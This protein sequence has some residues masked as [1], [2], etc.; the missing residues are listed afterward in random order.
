MGAPTV[1]ATAG[2][3]TSRS[4]AD[5]EVALVMCVQALADAPAARRAAVLLSRAGEHGLGPIALGLV[6]A[7]L[8]PGQRRSWLRAVVAVA[9]AHALAS[10]LKRLVRRPR[11]SDPRVDVRLAAPSPWSFPS[12][13]AASTTA[14]ALAYSRLLGR[15]LPLAAVPAMLASRV[16]VGLHY[17]SDVLAGAALGGV[18]ARA[19][20]AGTR[21]RSRRSPKAGGR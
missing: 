5:G 18:V 21:T 14:A 9:A 15:R 11:P 3:G 13:H 4:V 6:G 20:M 12:S 10:A 16:V 2:T 19:A 7:A 17:P 8:D 1:E